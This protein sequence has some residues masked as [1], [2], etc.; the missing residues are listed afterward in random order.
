LLKHHN[1]QKA[2]LKVQELMKS[3]Y[4]KRDC[5]FLERQGRLVFLAFLKPILNGHGHAFKE[6][7][8]SEEK[9]LDY[10]KLRRNPTVTRIKGG[11]AGFTDLKHHAEGAVGPVGST[12]TITS[13]L[14]GA[15]GPKCWSVNV[16]LVDGAQSKLFRSAQYASFVHFCF[17]C[18]AKRRSD[19]SSSHDVD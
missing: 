4:S 18:F 14:V 16:M 13:C 12:N 7:Q 15:V 5:D 17:F 19:G 2:L 9:R 8:T 6:P 10:W 3:E 1:V 11:I